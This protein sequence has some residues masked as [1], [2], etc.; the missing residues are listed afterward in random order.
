MKILLSFLICYFSLSIALAQ[1]E[2]KDFQSEAEYVLDEVFKAA[3]E[4]NYSNLHLLC[5][6]NYDNDAD[7]QYIC[8][9]DISSEKHKKEFVQY[10]EDARITGVIVYSTT[11]NGLEKAEVPFWYNHPGGKSRSNETMNMVR[12]D[13]KWYLLSF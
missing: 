12:I 10:F 11:A 9:I 3:K 8:D 4:Q 1:I 6:N 2:S 13:G 7:T 5:P